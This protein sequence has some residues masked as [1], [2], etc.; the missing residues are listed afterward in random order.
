MNEHL[1]RQFYTCFQNRDWKGMQACY[2]DDAF[3]YDPVFE[4]LEGYEVKAMWEM[5]LKSASDLQ[6]TFS[7]IHADED[8]GSC[9]WVATYTFSRTGRRVVNKVLARFKFQEGKIAEHQDS[10]DLWKWSRQ[11]LGV[12]GILLG[13]TPVLQ[14]KVRAMARKNLDKFITNCSNNVQSP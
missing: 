3:F 8:Y 11:A 7:D 5:L 12:P 4:N 14:K 2:G 10:F 13:W 6:I 9:S 1:I